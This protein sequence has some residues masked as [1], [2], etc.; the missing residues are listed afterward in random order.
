[1]LTGS[2]SHPTQNW[3]IVK[4]ADDTHDPKSAE[5]LKV[6]SVKE[7]HPSFTLAIH[8]KDGIILDLKGGSALNDIPV[9]GWVDNDGVGNQHWQF[10]A[11]PLWNVKL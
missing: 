7:F 4:D 5:Y 11:V 1:M 8:P 3:N 10:L 9:Q 2:G 6:T